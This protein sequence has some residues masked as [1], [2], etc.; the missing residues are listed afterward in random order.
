MR[1][2]KNY[3]KKPMDLQTLLFMWVA[4]FLLKLLLLRSSGKVI[5]GLQFFKIL[6]IFQDLVTSAKNS[7]ANNI[8]LSCLCNLSSL[9]FFSQNGVWT[10]LV[11][12]ILHIQ[13][14]RF[15]SSQ[16][17]IIL[18]NGLNL[19]HLNIHRMSRLFISLKL[20]FSPYFSFL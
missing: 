16:P 11:L 6:V 15:L 14:G 1:M 8:F 18:R 12:L 7:L 5:V 17:Q 9:I 3:Y 2:H 19:S 10:L 20:I 13:Q 4:T